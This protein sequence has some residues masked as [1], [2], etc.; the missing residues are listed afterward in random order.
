MHR[1]GFLITTALTVLGLASCS[2][3]RPDAAT[4]ASASTS[5]STSPGTQQFRP[6]TGIV[7]AAVPHGTIYALPGNGRHLALT[8]DDGTDATVVAAY[9]KF[10]ADT[11][12]R[13]TCF[14]NGV[15]RGWTDSR[16]VLAPMVESGQVFL[17]NH[18]WSHPDLRTLSAA[19]VSDQV[20]RN[21]KFL[22]STY[23]VS[24]RPFLRPPFGHYNAALARQL[25]DLGYPAITM[26]L[27]SLSDASVIAPARV[28]FHAKQWFLPQHL[29]IG[30]ANH[31]A[32]THVYGQL[33]DIIKERNLQ[34]V[35]LA[36][37]FNVDA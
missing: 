7:K 23:G 5:K 35:T 36:D 17:A 19:E 32:V 29:V 16:A 1:R 27:G 8:V 11:G 15:N 31:P 25:S 4:S 13:I 20:T 14:V 24:G 10:C 28:V 30:H 3:Q 21:E 26:W 33:V 18:T 6:P 2:S 34:P 12:M 9:A 37:V 22:R